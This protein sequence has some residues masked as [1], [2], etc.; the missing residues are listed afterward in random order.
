M[1]DLPIPKIKKSEMSLAERFR[2]LPR[3]Q[4]VAYLE[5]MYD[6]GELDTLKQNWQ[7]WGR[8][9][10]Q[11]PDYES[12]DVLLC[13]AGRGSG[14]TRLAAEGVHE[15]AKEPI[16]IALIG[17]TAAEVRDVMIE[18][19][20]GLVATQKAWNPIEY[21]PSKRRVLWLQSGAWATTYSGDE[22]GQLRGPNSS[23]AWC[24]ELAKWKRPQE[25]WDNLQMVLRVTKNPHCIISTTPRPIP[26][27]KSL[28]KRAEND[29]Y[30]IVRR[31][32][33]Y[34]NAANL[35]PR[36]IQRML[37]QYEGTRLGRQELHAE[38]LEDTEG[39]L[40]KLSQIDK[41]RVSYLPALSMITVG[42]DPPTST[43]GECG[44]VVMGLSG[45]DIYCLDDLSVS[46]LPEEW[47]AQVVSAYHKW[48]AD[49]VVPEKNQGGDMVMS[50][51]RAIDPTVPMDPVWASRGKRTRAEPISTYT[52]KG[53]VHHIGSF[54]TLED[55]L[56]TWV[57][58]ESDSPNRLDAY[59]HAATHL[60]NL[61][62]Y[63]LK[64][65][66]ARAW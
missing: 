36:Y 49:V 6:Q 5:R 37:G 23:R 16:H 8:P 13:L 28:T 42:V 54:A 9:E 48:S 33:T 61:T 22:P 39:A 44:I 30:I 15:W 32:S 50:T 60:L 51:I 46:G 62:P 10:Q 59:V 27:I 41:L 56:C 26:L 66:E 12:W 4:Q 25:T 17:E 31:W 63:G 35:S 18:G 29:P 43:G 21:Q 52:E 65:K 53:A 1:I 20:S 55:E 7:F 64:S 57:S 45:D 47:G 19:P 24:D 14:K 2:H 38:I 3:D 58:G 40:W 34:R 11:L